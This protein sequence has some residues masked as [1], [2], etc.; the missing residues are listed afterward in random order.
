M[1]LFVLALFIY[2]CVGINLF[3]QIKQRDSLNDKFN[4]QSFSGSMV[5]LMKFS[6]GDDWSA[7]MFEAAIK[8]D[9]ETVSTNFRL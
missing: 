7:F 9:C 5:T 2:A 3:A 8:E 6:T 4:F 1:S